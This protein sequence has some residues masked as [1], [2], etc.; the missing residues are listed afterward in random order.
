M[1]VWF[2]NELLV[3]V[4]LCCNFL[5]LLLYLYSHVCLVFGFFMQLCI[6]YV[7]H[8]CAC[9]A[10]WGNKRRI[11]IA[12]LPGRSRDVTSQLM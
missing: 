10:S 1:L 6:L 12:M 8:V 2:V 3:L 4:G 7:F 5:L 11:I 9:A